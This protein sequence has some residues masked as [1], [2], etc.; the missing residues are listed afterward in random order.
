MNLFNMIFLITKRNITFLLH[1]LRY[2][3]VLKESQ[4]RRG[5]RDN[6]TQFFHLSDEET[7]AQKGKMIS[8]GHM[9]SRW[10]SWDLKHGVLVPG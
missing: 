7:E 8:Q 1:I 5:L 6:L 4:G 10:Q 9:A 2:F 3:K